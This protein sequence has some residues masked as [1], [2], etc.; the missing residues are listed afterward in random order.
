MEIINKK[1]KLPTKDGYFIYGTIS[2]KQENN[3]NLL[4]FIHGLSGNQ[5]SKLFQTAS[6]FFCLKQYTTFRF[7]LYGK[8]KTARKISQTPL[9]VQTKDLNTVIS[10]L[11][12]EYENIYLIGHSLGGYLTLTTQVKNIKGKILWDSS[13]EPNKISFPKNYSKK[14]KTDVKKI[15]TIKSLLNT[16]QKSLDFIFAEKGAFKIAPQTYLQYLP[17]T[18]KIYLIN[19]ADHIFSEEKS[20]YKLFSI[21]LQLLK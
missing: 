1:I 7:N 21:T 19:K 13:M 14:V 5:N 4:I 12:K 8:N 11:K 18:K 6:D 10:N 3:K 16:N 9:S 17:K 15:P 20:K 2:H